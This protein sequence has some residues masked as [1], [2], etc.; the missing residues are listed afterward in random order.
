MQAKPDG[1]AVAAASGDAVGE[2]E[3]IKGSGSD[4]EIL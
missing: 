3:D 2:S 1:V 4:L